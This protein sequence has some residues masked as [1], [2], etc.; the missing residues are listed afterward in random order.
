[1]DH[2]TPLIVLQQRLGVGKICRGPV[3]NHDHFVRITHESEKQALSTNKKSSSMEMRR[4]EESMHS[5]Y[6]INSSR[7]IQV[8]QEWGETYVGCHAFFK[9]IRMMRVRYRKACASITQ[10]HEWTDKLSREICSIE[11]IR[12]WRCQVLNL[13]YQ[14]IYGTSDFVL[15]ETSVFHVSTRNPRSCDLLCSFAFSTSPHEPTNLVNN[16]ASSLTHTNQHIAT[17][18]SSRVNA[19]SLQTLQ[20]IENV[21][22]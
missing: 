14:S 17:S 4:K 18:Y 13:W 12:R 11:K 9:R 7:E 20:E 15:C 5:Q 1:M 2:P 21:K 19:N 22:C 6:F 16:D 10:V 8:S 3:W